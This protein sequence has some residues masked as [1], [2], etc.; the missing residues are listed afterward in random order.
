[1]R[2]SNQKNEKIIKTCIYTAIIIFVFIFVIKTSNLKESKDLIIDSKSII[3]M[4]ENNK[5]EIIYDYIKNRDKVYVLYAEN[6]D[7]KKYIKTH[8]PS[9]KFIGR[10]KLIFYTLFFKDKIMF[11]ASDDKLIDKLRFF[12]IHY[13][14]V[15]LDI[16]DIN[17]DEYLT[18][19]DS[20]NTKLFL[21]FTNKDF[22][23][24][25]SNYNKDLSKYLAVLDKDSIR[26]VDGDTI[27]YK[28][29]YY[30]FIGLD[31]P[32][33]KQNY[34]TNVKAYVENKIK[35]ASNVSMLVG[36]YDTFGRILCH[37]FI[38]D[39]PLA[40]PMM[41]DNQAKETIMKYGDNGF[42]NIASNIVYLSKFQG[43]RPFTDPAKFRSENR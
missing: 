40:Y 42:V 22:Y 33:L 16:N 34:G 13:S 36:S 15:V 17:R 10:F 23:N 35:N 25:D 43:R 32:E 39:I 30:R 26:V 14:R 24:I 41:K 12:K 38:D 21:S 31:A 29:N 8:F 18:L 5:T 19:K 6:D 2:T 4:I 11:Y 37:L 28:D 3:S 9:I 1:M 27:K 7:D 20:Y